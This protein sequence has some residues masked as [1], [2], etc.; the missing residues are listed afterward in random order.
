M[1]LEITTENSSEK[2]FTGKIGE[3]DLRLGDCIELMD[4]IEDLSVDAIITD[5]PYMIGA[6][7]IGDPS[8]KAGSWPDL[9]NASL[10]Y[11][12]WMAKCWKKLKPGGHM[13]SFLNWR[14]V[15]ILLKA[16]ADASIPA[17]SLAVWDK[18]WIGPA[19]PAQL[20][21]RYEM[22]LFCGKDGAKIQ[23]R[24]QPDVFREKWM[25][26]NMG[27]SGH[28]AEKPLKLLKEIVNLVTKEGDTVLD[29]FTG[30]GTTGIAAIQNGRNFIGIEANDKYHKI[31]LDRLA[32]A[33]NNL[34][35]FDRA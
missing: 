5:P 16:C 21:C 35:G 14:S 26:G 13:I 18:E 27:K 25:A 8:S 19:G 24:S 30:S 4:Q 10:W 23:N 20:R 31:A 1:K 33:K 7:S 29:P 28:P 2:N 22:I 6:I 32:G 15:P 3:Y 34:N 12:E 9:M 17:S 11:R